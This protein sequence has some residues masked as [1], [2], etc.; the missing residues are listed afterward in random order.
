[1]TDTNG[2][3][4]S[5]I[6][7]PEFAKLLLIGS[8][9]LSLASRLYSGSIICGELLD[10]WR[11]TP[12]P[13]L[14]STICIQMWMFIWMWKGKKSHCQLPWV[15]SRCVAWS[16]RIRPTQNIVAAPP[17]APQLHHPKLYTYSPYR[18]PP[19]PRCPLKKTNRVNTPSPFPFLFYQTLY[20]S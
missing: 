18:P 10:T 8:L 20:K 2:E 4:L 13:R 5:T 16:S 14:F 19:P 11:P 7:H 17:C 1:M 3:S 12:V 9:P 15:H 6:S